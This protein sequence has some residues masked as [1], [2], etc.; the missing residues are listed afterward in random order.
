MNYYRP[1][2]QGRSMAPWTIRL[3]AIN[4]VIF[5]LML[6][7]RRTVGG[8]LFVNE[9]ILTPGKVF[10]GHIWQLVTYMFLHDPRS[11]YHIGMN[12]FVLWMFGR[13]VE[14]NLGSASF[15]KIYF[16]SGVI[17][18]LCSLP[19]MHPVLGASGAV[20]GILGVYGQLFPDRTVLLFFIIP[21]K[22]RYMIWLIAI[23]DL[24]GAIVGGGN[25]AHF[26]HIGGLFAGI[27]IMRTGLYKRGLDLT[28]MRRKREIDRQRRVKERVNEI[29]D[30]VNREGIGSLSR[31]EHDFLKKVR[32]G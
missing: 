5:V 32:K 28:E 11:L 13:E 24:F 17:A 20:L 8:T 16:A 3:I 30:K 21:I 25:V 9:L 10:R 6:I 19:M 29:L 26:A 2:G 12:M 27:I 14:Y 7:L 31:Q 1:G 15:L 22:M 23:G 4:L 18:G